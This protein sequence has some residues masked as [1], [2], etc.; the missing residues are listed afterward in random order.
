L[1]LRLG[2]LLDEL[3]LSGGEGR[4]G[5]RGSLAGGLG[6]IGGRGGRRVVADAGQQMRFDV[7][8]ALRG[9][10]EPRQADQGDQHHQARAQREQRARRGEPRGGE[11]HD[12]DRAGFADEDRQQ[13]A[14]LVGGH[15]GDLR[16][17]GAGAPRAQQ[18]AGMAFEQRAAGQRGHALAGDGAVGQ[19]EIGRKG[20]LGEG[21]ALQ[22]PIARAEQDVG[23][24]D[25]GGQHGSDVGTGPRLGLER[26]GQPGTENEAE[27]ADIPN[28]RK[29]AVAATFRFALLHVFH[30]SRQNN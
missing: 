25:A 17:G 8:G 1:V 10:L 13:A 24:G 4:Q 15:D 29:H 9:Q 3:G 2:Q 11:Q 14:G 23:Q 27:D 16:A 30:L 6:E 7:A 22:E 26:N 19:V 20:I 28:A 21:Q 12:E 5:F 18:A